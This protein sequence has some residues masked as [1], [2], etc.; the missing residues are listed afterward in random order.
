M[1]PAAHRV[2]KYCIMYKIATTPLFSHLFSILSALCLLTSSLGAQ[3]IYVNANS[4]GCPGG[5]GASWATAFCSLQSALDAAQPGN[6]IWVAQ[7]TYL[8]E[9]AADGSAPATHQLKTF[10]INKNIKL[11]GGFAGTESSLNQRNWALNPTILSG[12]VG[13]P[14]VNPDNAYHVVWMNNVN[15]SALLNGFIIEKGWA[16]GPGG[17][18]SDVGAGLYINGDNG[19]DSSPMIVNC[20]FRNN[21]CSFSSGAAVYVCAR[22]SGIARP[23]FLQCQFIQGPGFPQSQLRHYARASGKCEPIYRQCTFTRSATHSGTYEITN[24]LEFLAPAATRAYMKAYNSIIWNNNYAVTATG[25]SSG[26]SRADLFNCL[27]DSLGSGIIPSNS[28]LYQDPLF[29]DI[30]AADFSLQAGSPAINA[31]NNAYLDT[32]SKDLSMQSRLVDNLVD[33]GVFEFQSNCL[34]G[35]QVV[36]TASYANCLG[37]A[38]VAVSG[39]MPPFAYQWS[40]GQ[41]GATASG[42]AAGEYTVTVADASGCD[43]VGM[44]Q[45]AAPPGLQLWV[46]SDELITC[47]GLT[48]Q[49][50]ASAAGGMPPYAY[51][52]SDGQLGPEAF[53]LGAGTYGVTATDANGCEAMATVVVPGFTTLD[54]ELTAIV[55]VSCSGTADGSASVSAS[56]GVPPYSYLWSSGQSGPLADDLSAGVHQVFVSDAVG[57]SASVTLL[58][59]APAELSVAVEADHA[60]SCS[61]L[62]GQA[63]ATP[64]GGTPPYAYAWSNGHAGPA[65]SGLTAGFHAVTITDASGC[66][67]TATVLIFSGDAD[68]ESEVVIQQQ[69][70][71]GTAHDGVASVSITGGIFPYEYAWSDGQTTSVAIGLP[72]GQHAVAITDA[73]GCTIVDTVFL[74]AQYQMLVGMNLLQAVTCHN[75]STGSIQANPIGGTPPFMYLWD[76]GQTTG[77]L[78]GLPAGSYFVTITDANGCMVSGGAMLQNPPLLELALETVFPAC[79]GDEDGQ[80]AVIASG[81][82]PPYSYQ[83]SNGQ[84]GPIALGLAAGIYSL[85]VTDANGCTAAASVDLPA[86]PALQV[87]ITAASPASCLEATDGTAMASAEGGV[88]PY[89]YLW[90]D[91][92]DGQTAS[93]LA[94]GLYTVNL[95]DS[96]GCEATAA[97][98]ISALAYEPDLTISLEGYTLIAAESSAEYQWIDCNTG[99]PLAGANAQ[100]YNVEIDGAYAVILSEGE[101]QATSECVE[102][103]IVSTSEKG[104]GQSQAIAFP[105]PNEGQYTLYLPWAA[106]LSL[107]DSAGRLLR[108]R[109][110]PAGQHDMEIEGPAG[111]YLLVLRSVE[112]VQSLRLVRQ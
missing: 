59:P 74:T 42:L 32:L 97:A 78:S 29:V 99:L 85:S 93:G 73:A 106:E 7:G 66:Q 36:V 3:V 53:D 82:T 45:L 51:Q 44:V 64:S 81:G 84:D 4:P 8:P 95:V 109:R 16:N 1:R 18:N 102:V 86:L 96:N 112:G 103:V 52:W 57:C 55:P 75:S 30:Q 83:W 60:S 6:Q 72:P 28:L 47:E 31:G 61:G 48:S 33:I 9:K 104:V 77:N 68:L 39:G 89:T 50:L 38:T 65:A 49:A 90:S 22:W 25:L 5:N 26:V 37:Q 71:C 20:T 69:P 2:I 15:T 63:E 56:G 11:Y 14:D 43:A 17:D 80:A 62:D 105:N 107:Y 111:I 87:Q 34:N 58:V 24:Q 27:T 70:T 100:S 10:F 46:E 94:P 79:S 41:T 23:V 40:D 19:V 54:L 108:S 12:D 35:P 21:F 67:A 76:N 92:Q 91:G 101:C 98:N 88:P 13:T 110:Y